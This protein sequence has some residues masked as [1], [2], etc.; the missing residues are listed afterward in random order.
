MA[1]SQG[2]FTFRDVAI[3]FSQEEWECL[4]PSQRD[5]YRDVMLE[6][7][8]NLVS[9]DYLIGILSAGFAI[10]KLSPR[11][12]TNLGELYGNENHGIKDFDLKEVCENM[13]KSESEWGYDARNDIKKCF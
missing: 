1:L 5:L 11:E 6:T 13:Q 9:L 3:E 2:L 12:N 8:R 10:N 4:A 7:Y